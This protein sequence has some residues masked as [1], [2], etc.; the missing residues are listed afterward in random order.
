V[1]SARDEPIQASSPSRRL[2]ILS[3]LHRVVSS[4]S[5]VNSFE[6]SALCDVTTDAALLLSAGYAG[7]SSVL[8]GNYNAICP[9]ETLVSA[10]EF[11]ESLQGYKTERPCPPL[12][13]RRSPDPTFANLRH[14]KIWSRYFP[15]NIVLYVLPASRL[16]C[17]A[18]NRWSHKRRPAPIDLLVRLACEGE[19]A[20]SMIC[21]PTRRFRTI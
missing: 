5:F 8:V 16:H 4:V 10:T 7:R 20:R 2:P 14:R 13:R 1:A 18:F 19:R 15:A 9:G 11:L 17:P 6:A 12:P 3:G 21:E